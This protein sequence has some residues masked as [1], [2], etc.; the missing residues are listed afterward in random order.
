MAFA[1]ACLL[2]DLPEALLQFGGIGQFSVS[3]GQLQPADEHL[4]P[5]GHLPVSR[6]EPGHG[7]VGGGV[8]Q[9]NGRP[10]RCETR[11]HLV[12]QVQV[13][14]LRIVPKGRV[15]VGSLAEGLAH[16]GPGP[17]GCEV[18]ILALVADS[19]IQAQIARSSTLPD[20]VVIEP[21]SY[22]GIKSPNKI[23]SMAIAIFLGLVVP[24]AY[25]FGRRLLID[26]IEDKE[27]LKRL[28]NLTQV[29]E[30]PEYK[31]FSGN[32]V[33]NEP[34]EILAESFR[35]LRSNINF[36]LNGDKH[37]IILLTSSIPLEGKSM[38]SLT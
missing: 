9:Q 11:H 18:D 22:L 1:V 36:F 23:I 16:G 15:P 12:H 31:G 3:V 28:C 17:R 33:I 26:K 35:T 6:L 32:I 27:D 38:T 8:V 5:L 21:A 20:C 4:G 29:G 19:R 7:S 14:A 34:T 25:V 37:K 24:S 30:L 2:D 13:E 10:V